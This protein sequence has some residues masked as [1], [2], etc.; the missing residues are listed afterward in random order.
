MQN[1]FDNYTDKA[2]Y[3]V[4]LYGGDS[5]AG[6]KLYLSQSAMSRRIQRAEE[7]AGLQIFERNYHHFSPTKEGMG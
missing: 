1:L 2:V 6:E 5:K 7:R 4:Y 3:Y